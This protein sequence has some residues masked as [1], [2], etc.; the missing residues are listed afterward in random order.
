MP[1]KNSGGLSIKAFEKE[2]GEGAAISG[3]SAKDASVERRERRAKQ[4]GPPRAWS[5]LQDKYRARK[6]WLIRNIKAGAKI[7]P[8]YLTGLAYPADTQ[9]AELDLLAQVALQDY[10]AESIDK[11]LRQEKRQALERWQVGTP[12]DQRTCLGIGADQ[13]IPDYAVT[14][15][16]DDS[17]SDA[18]EAPRG[19]RVLPAAPPVPPGPSD[20]E[21]EDFTT[22]SDVEPTESESNEEGLE[23]DP[24][25]NE[26]STYLLII[27][28]PFAK[29][30]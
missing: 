27:A 22:S 1:A 10:I 19:Q 13:N 14:D 20:P 2:F 17:G 5:M 30:L 21:D 8:R 25:D 16:E 6:S 18:S 11:E 29:T 12:Q 15:T 4:R 26:A 24:A 3:S 28:F 9:W 23:S 7:P